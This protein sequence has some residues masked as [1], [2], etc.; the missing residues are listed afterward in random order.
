MSWRHL[1]GTWN[2]DV[3]SLAFYSLLPPARTTFTSYQ[4]CP[5]TPSSPL[6][7][8]LVQFYF[9]YKRMTIKH[10]RTCMRVYLRDLFLKIVHL[11]CDILWTQISDKKRD[12]FS[13]HFYGVCVR[14]GVS[15]SEWVSEWVTVIANRVTPQS[16]G[17]R[18]A[19]DTPLHSSK[20]RPHFKTR[21]SLERKNHGHGSRRDP[22][23]TMT[24][25]ARASSNLLDWT[26][27]YAI[28]SSH[29]SES[30]ETVKYDH[31]S[32][33]DP[34]PRMIMLA[35]ARNNLLDCVCVCVCVCVCLGDS[36]G[37]EGYFTLLSVPKTLYRIML[38]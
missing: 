16:R 25:L 33:R 18:P 29:P 9:K 7:F 24:V 10:S 4:Q 32:R 15:Q 30:R 1:P 14:H 22:K 23:P 37:G 8:T 11:I 5:I 20:R 3:T 21:K 26:G 31:E 19:A 35:R 34:K 2:P 12:L 27:K 38:G 13:S 36:R 6:Q 17:E 28:S